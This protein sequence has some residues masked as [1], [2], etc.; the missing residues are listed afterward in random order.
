MPLLIRKKARMKALFRVA[1]DR[2]VCQ[3][4]LQRIKIRIE[5]AAQ[6]LKEIW[7]VLITLLKLFQKII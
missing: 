1:K 5:L 4:M 7:E 3:S 6:R 2:Q